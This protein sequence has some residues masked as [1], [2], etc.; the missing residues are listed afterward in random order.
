MV[1]LGLG[2]PELGCACPA[3][4]AATDERATRARLVLG[5]GIGGAGKVRAVRARLLAEANSPVAA[6][7]SANEADRATRGAV[8]FI[9][10]PVN[11]MSSQEKKI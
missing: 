8:D 1:G 9:F 3:A 6:E 11:K 4:E 10:R 2:G 7:A 5:A